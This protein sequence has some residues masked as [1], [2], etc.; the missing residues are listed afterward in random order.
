MAIKMT[1]RNKNALPTNGI[2]NEIVKIITPLSPPQV[3]ED[4]FWVHANFLRCYGINIRH[5]GS[6]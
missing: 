2:N 6:K 1:E 3:I 5:M 4:E